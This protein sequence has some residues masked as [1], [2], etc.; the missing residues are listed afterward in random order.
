MLGHGHVDV[1]HELVLG[2]GVL[3]DDAAFFDQ[4]NLDSAFFDQRFKR[5][6]VG[7]IAIQTVGFL[8]QHDST[9]G[10]G[11][12]QLQHVAELLAARILRRL[13]IDEFVRDVETANAS[14]F[15]QQFSLSRNRVAFAFLLATGDSGI[16]D[17]R[18][19]HS[20]R[21]TV[22]HGIQIQAF[23]KGVFRRR[24]QESGTQLPASS[25][26][27]CVLERWF[28]AVYALLTA[29][30]RSFEGKHSVSHSAFKQSL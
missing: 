18:N 3:S 14:V 2:A 7:A 8:D 26:G 10:V 19:H 12:Q 11:F 25:T 27:P 17:H 30:R 22:V 1:M 16:E 13:D 6:G 23:C 20:P 29:F 15:S 28:I 5:E 9:C 21:H 4:M 24:V